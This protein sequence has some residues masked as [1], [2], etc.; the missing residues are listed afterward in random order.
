MIKNSSFEV[1]DQFAQEDSDQFAVV[2]NENVGPSLVDLTVRDNDFV[3]DGPT[4]TGV[5]GFTVD[6][7]R[8]VDND[9][10]GEGRAGVLATT[11]ARWRI[12]N[13]DFCDLF[14][15]PSPGNEAQAPVVIVNSV[16]IRATNND[17][18]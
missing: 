7:A 4:Q 3:L 5:A 2:V 11:S 9:F 14:I 15:P 10:S 18:A 13:N 8:I 17:C 1:S 16:D 12:R 6:G